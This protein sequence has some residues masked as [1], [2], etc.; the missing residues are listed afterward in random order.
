MENIL[1]DEF[2]LLGAFQSCCTS[3]RHF[4]TFRNDPEPGAIILYEPV[5]RTFSSPF[6][7]SSEKGMCVSIHYCP[8]CGKKFPEE[9]EEKWW[10]TLENE[11]GIVRLNDELFEDF[12]K[13]VPSEFRT[14]E[15]WKKRGL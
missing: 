10:K 9:L 2:Y 5:T 3:F 1:N 4:A 12:T 8:F 6:G 14:D 7:N 15:W 13:R 11:L